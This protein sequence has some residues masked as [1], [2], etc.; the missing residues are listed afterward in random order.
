MEISSC[1]SEAASLVWVAA[2]HRMYA[3]TNIL[4]IH[5][6][7]LQDGRNGDEVNRAGRDGET[8]LWRAAFGGDADI[9]QLLLAH[10]ASVSTPNTYGEAPLWRAASDG[11]MDVAKLLLQHGAAIDAPDAD[12]QTPLWSAASCSQTAVVKLLLKHGAALEAVDD[13]GFT[14]LHAAS[15]TG[16]VDVVSC[17]LHHGAGINAIA[18]QGNDTPTTLLSLTCTNVHA[19]LVRLLLSSGANGADAL[20]VARQCDDFEEMRHFILWLC[21]TGRSN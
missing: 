11:G 16:A 7:L 12:G 6:S 5:F 4:L 20:A 8:P 1:D 13:K 10:G 19:E 3:A 14:P 21:T 17:L 15:Q 9:V 2:L 18:T